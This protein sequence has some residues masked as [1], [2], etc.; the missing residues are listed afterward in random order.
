MFVDALVL[1]ALVLGFVLVLAFATLYNCKSRNDILVGVLV[2]IA[3]V[4]VPGLAFV[5]DQQHK[6]L[7]GPSDRIRSSSRYRTRAHL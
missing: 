1:A 2:G 4:A 7:R 6:T 5:W 3:I